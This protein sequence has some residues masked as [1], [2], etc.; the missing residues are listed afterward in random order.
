MDPFLLP[1]INCVKFIRWQITGNSHFDLNYVINQED[2]LLEKDAV[3]VILQ[4]FDILLS[5][6]NLI[7]LFAIV[8]H[9]HVL[10]RD[11]LSYLFDSLKQEYNVSEKTHNEF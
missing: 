2:N 11:L 10:V 9:K 8:I 1:N 4:K 3:N 5:E 6:Y 7:N